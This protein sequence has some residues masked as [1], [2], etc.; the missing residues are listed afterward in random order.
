MIPARSYRLRLAHKVASI[1]GLSCILR[2]CVLPASAQL[3]FGTNAIVFAGLAANG[4]PT[5]ITNSPTLTVISNGFIITGYNIT[6]RANTTNYIEA[7]WQASRAFTLA[8][9]RDVQVA[10]IG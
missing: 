6:L 8:R 9:Q 3:D 2:I 10:V 7:S 1:L 4:S 5:I